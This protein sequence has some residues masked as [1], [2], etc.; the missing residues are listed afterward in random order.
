MTCKLFC[1]RKWADSG[2]V[3]R[4][5]WVHLWQCHLLMPRVPSLWEG[6]LCRTLVWI[7]RLTP[8]G[9]WALSSSAWLLGG[10]PWFEQAMMGCFGTS[11]AAG[12][13]GRQRW[14]QRIPTDWHSL[15]PLLGGSSFITIY[16]SQ[17]STGPLGKS[18]C[19]KKSENWLFFCLFV[20]YTKFA[21]SSSALTYETIYVCIVNIFFNKSLSAA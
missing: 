8:A 6:G 21:L 17:V 16:Y 9:C 10:G 20:L 13:L 19:L 15:I 2:L 4:S 3:Y 12:S 18:S 7:P 1:A 5:C 14:R 11:F